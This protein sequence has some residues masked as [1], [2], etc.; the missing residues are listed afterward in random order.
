MEQLQRI[1][2]TILTAATALKASKTSSKQTAKGYEH[3]SVQ[4]RFLFNTNTN[5]KTT[6]D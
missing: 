2:F 4:D 5:I 3:F 1:T 6:I